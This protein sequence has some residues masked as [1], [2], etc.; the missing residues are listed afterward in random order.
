[1]GT[2]SN[3]GATQEDGTIKV[4]YCHWDGYPEGVGAVLTEHYTEPAKVQALLNLGD[5]SSLND[6]EVENVESYAKRGETDTEA[7][8]YSTRE[9][10]FK[11]YRRF[12][13]G[14]SLH[15]RGQLWRRI[16]VELFPRISSLDITKKNRA[17][18]KCLKATTITQSRSTLADKREN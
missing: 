12:R 17:G 9:E 11:R 16:R 15:I 4:I 2:R 18:G 8:I 1:M 13:R 7:R 14:V 6:T 5:I 10:W 3:I